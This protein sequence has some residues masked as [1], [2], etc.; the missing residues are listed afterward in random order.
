VCE[1]VGVDCMCVMCAVSVHNVCV[2]V[3]VCVL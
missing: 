1:S 2:T 3:C